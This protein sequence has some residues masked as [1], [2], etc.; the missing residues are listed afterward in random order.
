MS[1]SAFINALRRFIAIRGKVQMFRSD[2]GSNFVGATDHIGVHTINVENGK[3]KDFLSNSGSIWVF[4]SPHSSHMGGAWERMIGVSRRILE[5]V[6]TKTHNLTHD[7]LVTLMAEVSAIVNAR[8]IVP[9]SSDP[10]CPQILSPA[11]LLT[12]K[13]D[14]GQQPVDGLTMKDLYKDQWK[15][16]QY[17]ANQFWLRWRKEFLQS[18][19]SRPKWK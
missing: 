6:L 9:V 5:A 15:R 3:I 14:S 7:V 13:F 16:V 4:N 1:S 8:P 11:A 10:D 2:R 19:Q 17:L 18:L 12:M